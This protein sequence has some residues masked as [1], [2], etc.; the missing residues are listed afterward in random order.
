VLY[1]IL[2]DYNGTIFFA[3]N[4]I[5]LPVFF[6]ITQ[7]LHARFHRFPVPHPL[8]ISTAANIGLIA[9]LAS[10]AKHD[11]YALLH[12]YNTPASMNIFGGFSSKVGPGNI[13]LYIL[14]AAIVSMALPINSQKSHLISHGIELLSVSALISFS[15]IFFTI[16][17]ARLLRVSPYVIHSILL[18][19]ATTPIA[20][21]TIGFIGGNSG[22]AGVMSVT[23]GV[24]GGAI[25][26]WLF[27]LNRF[28]KPITRGF[29][30]GSM[31]QGLGTAIITAE[32]PESAPFSSLSFVTVGVMSSIW[33]AIP[34]IRTLIKTMIES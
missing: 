32:E 16:F 14:N 17:V 1:G 34:P 6:T 22:I 5:A 9:I 18:R 15:S 21:A 30:M 8:L 12:S 31:A 33:I 19:T 2:S 10:V 4:I 7:Y 20:I 23:T 25:W 3:V 13:Y 29:T 27:N 24:I 28:T 26:L 11:F